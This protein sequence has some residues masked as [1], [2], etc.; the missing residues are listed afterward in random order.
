MNI[1]K[2]HGVS[3]STERCP[4]CALDAE[5]QFLREEVHRLRKLKVVLSR[6]IITRSLAATERGVV[7]T[8]G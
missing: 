8:H 7:V 6:S 1:C 3:F 5:N 4:A 2:Q